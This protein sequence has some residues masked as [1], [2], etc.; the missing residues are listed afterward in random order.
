MFETLLVA[1]GAPIEL[2]AHL[3]RLAHSARALYDA[4]PPPEARELILSHAAGT[5]LGRLRLNAVP[6]GSGAL[7]AAVATADVD[8]ALV[9]PGWERAVVLNVLS[10]PGG[11]GGHKWVDRD[12]LAAAEHDD[13]NAVPLVVD[14]DGTA[15]EASRAHVF[16]VRAGTILTPPADGRLLPGVA[17]AAA[18]EVAIAAGIELREQRLSLDDLVA[19]DEL[20]LTGSVRGVEP[21]R[22]IGDRPERSPGPATPVVAAAL[23]RRW[24]EL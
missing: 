10:V 17:R 22:T 7:A 20:F 3:A 11:I 16:A 9:F 21:V 1:D 18:I 2:D 5:A 14:G 24:L 15:L 12:L 6:D 4:A 23:R 13:P 8:P 19:A